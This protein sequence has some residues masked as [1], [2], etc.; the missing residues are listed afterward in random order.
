M[1]VSTRISVETAPSHPSSPLLSSVWEE[2]IG[3]QGARRPPRPG[4]SGLR[5]TGAAGREWR[6]G[7]ADGRQAADES[8]GVLERPAGRCAAGARGVEG[9]HGGPDPTDPGR[10]GVGDPPHPAPV[11]ARCPGRRG[12]PGEAAHHPHRCAAPGVRRRRAPAGGNARAAA[13]ARGR[14]PRG[15]RPGAGA[16]APGGDRHEGAA[17]PPGVPHGRGSPRSHGRSAAPPPGRPS[18]RRPSRPA[19]G[20]TGSP[21]GRTPPHRVGCA[22]TANAHTV[23]I[24]SRIAVRKLVAEPMSPDTACLRARQYNAVVSPRLSARRARASASSRSPAL[25]LLRARKRSVFRS[26][27]WAAACGAGH[28]PRRAR[29]PSGAG[30][31][32]HVSAGL[33]KRVGRS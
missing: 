28:G 11:R 6:R 27:W 19:T 30:L 33:P 5:P 9:G 26:P 15:R 22:R 32:T 23:P 10:G 8:G 1:Q 17:G 13:R 16:R 31:R 21:T 3:F 20:W 25:S 24:R 4:R 29:R 18:P 2:I 7:G 12:G 14:R